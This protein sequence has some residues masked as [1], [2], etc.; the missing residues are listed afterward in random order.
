MVVI[1]QFLNLRTMSILT[2][3]IT[4]VNTYVCYA[5]GF[6]K[7]A[8]AEKAL[9]CQSTFVHIKEAELSFFPRTTILGSLYLLFKKG[10]MS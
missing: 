7:Q 9:I 3:Q 2:F 4:E 10:Y 6:A 5:Q 1:L 8:L